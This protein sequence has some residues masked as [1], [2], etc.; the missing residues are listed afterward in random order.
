MSLYAGY[1]TDKSLPLSKVYSP[2]QKLAA[3]SCGPDYAQAMA[4]SAVTR[5]AVTTVSFWLFFGV[6]L[7]ILLGF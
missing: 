4:N 5:T 6:A 3:S 7:G 2:A 1:A